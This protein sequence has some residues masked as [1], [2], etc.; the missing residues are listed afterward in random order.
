LHENT[1]AGS[2]NHG[3]TIGCVLSFGSLAGVPAKRRRPGDLI[4][5]GLLAGPGRFFDPPKWFTVISDSRCGTRI[6]RL[7]KLRDKRA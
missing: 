7:R 6:A 5:T 2:N 4:P 1:I 3:S